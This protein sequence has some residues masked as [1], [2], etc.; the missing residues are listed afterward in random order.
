MR[1]ID[2]NTG[3]LANE[4]ELQKELWYILDEVLLLI[5]KFSPNVKDEFIRLREM[6]IASRAN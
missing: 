6:F 4:P 3:L 1:Y 5:E 2:I